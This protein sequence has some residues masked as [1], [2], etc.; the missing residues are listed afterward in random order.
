MVSAGHELHAVSLLDAPSVEKRLADIGV[1]YHSVPIAR[2][3]LNPFHDLYGLL[4]LFRLFYRLRPDYLLSYTVKP[5]IYGGL[6]ARLFRARYYAMITG[7]GYAFNDKSAKGRAVGMLVRALFRISLSSSKCVFFHNKDDCKSAQQSGLLKT[8]GRYVILNGSGVD[9]DYYTPRAFPRKVSFLMIARLL[10]DKGVYEYIEAARR[11][12]ANHPNLEFRLA[13]WVDENPNA[14]SREELESW[15]Y[16]GIIDYLGC[17]DDVRPAIADASVYVLP[18]Y[19]EGMPRTVLEAMAMSRPVITSDIP[20]C[21]DAVLDGKTGF[22][23]T[24]GDA[25][26]LGSTMMKFVENPDLVPVMGAAS[27]DYAREKFDVHAVNRDILEAMGLVG[28]A[29]A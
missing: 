9:L 15:V 13:G 14:I 7:M 17:L 2:T 10:V 19:H 23:V 27:L 28:E 24:S 29:A 20:G 8:Q 4:A 11:L 6:V 16:E 21:K 18:S 5:V 12:K 22:L 3:G 25:V 1:I 26:V